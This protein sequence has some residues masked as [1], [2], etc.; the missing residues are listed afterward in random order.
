MTVTSIRR[1]R[2]PKAPPAP[3][4]R[5]PPYDL[6][7]PE[8]RLALLGLTIEKLIAAGYVYIGM[9]HFALPQD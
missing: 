1:P 4:L 3:A 2:T 8:V 9:D 5:E 7:T 6:P